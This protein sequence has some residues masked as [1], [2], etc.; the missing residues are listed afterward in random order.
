MDLS[1]E[2]SDTSRPGRVYSRIGIACFLIL[3]IATA[4]Q[5]AGMLLVTQYAPKI[6]SKPWF[7]WLL[8]LV[9][10]YVIAVP[11][12]IAIMTRAP[13]SGPV[14]RSMGVGTFFMF[15]IMSLSVVYIGNIIGNLLSTA[16]G[17]LFKAPGFNPVDL[18]I[19]QSNTLISG[20]VLVVLAPLIEELIFRK[21]IIDRIRVYGEGMAVFLSGFMFGLFHGN[22]YQF[23]Y[24]FGLGA[25]FAYI[26]V[27][28]GRLRYPVILHMVINFMGGVFV[29]LV[30][31]KI[32]DGSLQSIDLSDTKALTQYFVGNLP[33]L[34][35]FFAYIICIFAAVVAGIVLFI[36][37]RKTFVLEPAPLR[38]A[39]G[40]GFRTVFL[41]VGM[42]LFTLGTLAMMAA[43][44]LN[45]SF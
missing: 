30:F 1:A 11:I 40:T 26:Y 28:T 33:L 15:L 39:K 37:R 25:L 3:V 16:I 22:L 7:F 10:Q 27:R 8:I 13:A 41:N 29:P 17:E 42:I 43:N 31:G 34:L 35:G 38:L 18:L 36:V 12:G 14:P 4:V 6:V 19:S 21:L 32:L 44:L 24:A 45:I 2:K 9:P 20:L 23:F 5:L